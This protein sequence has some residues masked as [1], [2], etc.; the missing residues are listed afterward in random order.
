MEP[1]TEA[2]ILKT[3]RSPSNP[4]DRQSFPENDNAL[5]LGAQ[6]D[7]SPAGNH[8]MQS[9]FSHQEQEVPIPI[10]SLG[11]EIFS[12]LL[13][14]VSLIGIFILLKQY[15]HKPSPQWSLGNWGITLNTVLSFLSLVFRSS[16]LMPVAQSI[17]QLAWIWYLQPK[18]LQDVVYYDSASRGPLGSIRLLLRLRFL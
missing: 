18:P 12:L 1:I 4:A 13:A 14:T 15:D 8:Q 11:Y 17:S 3:P 10:H 7:F 6:K 9:S 2:R 5:L 16:L